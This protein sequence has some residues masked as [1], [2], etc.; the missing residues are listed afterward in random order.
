MAAQQRGDTPSGDLIEQYQQVQAA[1]EADPTILA[2]AHAQQE[3]QAFMG[4]VSDEITEG[5][6]VDFTQ[7]AG[8]SGC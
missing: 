4:R 6:G 3:A 7:L 5:I 8:P 1:A 2:Y